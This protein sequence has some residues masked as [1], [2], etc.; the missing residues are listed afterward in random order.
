VHSYVSG[1]LVRQAAYPASTSTHEHAEC[2]GCKAEWL[3]SCSVVLQ[4]LCELQLQLLHEGGQS[5]TCRS[6]AV[7]CWAACCRECLGFTPLPC[8]QA[9]PPNLQLQ[10][11]T[12]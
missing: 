2:C 7:R 12:W 8:V 11:R 9:P 10:L 5:T 3:A 4:P 1:T 6:L